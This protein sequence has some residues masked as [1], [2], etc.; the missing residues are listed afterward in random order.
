[1]F[2][3]Q[4]CS[5]TLRAIKWEISNYTIASLF[6]VYHATIEQSQIKKYDYIARAR[7]HWENTL[8]NLL[9]RK[10]VAIFNRTTTTTKINKANCLK[11]FY[12]KKTMKHL[13]WI[14]TQNISSYLCTIFP[15]QSALRLGGKPM[16]S[17][18]N[19]EERNSAKTRRRSK[20]CAAV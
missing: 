4:T 11:S 1:M 15:V 5:A 16:L 8:W 2:V 19:I 18:T 20:M 6:A 13:R 14:E 10:K 17:S 12:R 3:L 9:K 7:Q